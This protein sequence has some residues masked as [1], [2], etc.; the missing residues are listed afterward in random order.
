MKECVRKRV[1]PRIIMIL[2]KYTIYYIIKV[3][4]EKR[5]DDE[6]VKESQMNLCFMFKSCG[7]MQSLTSSAY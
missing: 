1:E 2:K 4:I 5:R 6:M 7:M 3:K